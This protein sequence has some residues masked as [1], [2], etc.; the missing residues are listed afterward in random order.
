MNYDIRRILLSRSKYPVTRK[1]KSQRKDLFSLKL[2]NIFLT[3][4]SVQK[5]PIIKNT[6]LNHK[7]TKLPK[8]RTNILLSFEEDSKVTKMIDRLKMPILPK[9]EKSWYENNVR[10]SVNHNI[11]NDYNSGRY[12][13]KEINKVLN[14]KGKFN[15]NITISKYFKKLE[16]NYSREKKNNNSGRKDN[17]FLKTIENAKTKKILEKFSNAHFHKNIFKKEKTKINLNFKRL[18]G[19][20]K[21]RKLNVLRNK[22]TTKSLVK[23]NVFIP[24]I[25]NSNESKDNLN[26]LRNYYE[27]FIELYNSY[28]NYSK[29]TF[30]INNFNKTY[31]YSFNIKSIQKV[32]MNTQFLIILK[33]S[34]ILIICLIFLSKDEQLYNESLV[35]MEDNFEKFIML[36]LNTFNYKS[37]DSSKINKFVNMS[38]NSNNEKTLNELLN[39][40]IALLFDDKLNDYK[41]LK[42]S[43]RQLLNNIN[44]YSTDN[45]IN[46]I[47]KCI[48]YC[49]NCKYKIEGK[50]KSK[51]KKKD[52]N[53]SKMD[54]SISIISNIN[55]PFIKKKWKKNFV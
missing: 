18:E 39:N 37:L 29:Y 1:A 20:T 10:K 50:D 46:I 49:Y 40:I 36:C 54:D 31:I 12:V 42:K 9:K 24:S 41:K 15:Q 19:I 48:L 26:F 55:E 6:S 25:K 14:S 4:P 45:M 30:L 47:N 44:N 3:R 22:S 51:K 28:Y 33:Y 17:F 11:F 21:F 23:L 27:D 52:K 53:D 35:K 34:S 8:N 5:L 7:I 13:K 32:S 2:D 43:L 38:R 16:L